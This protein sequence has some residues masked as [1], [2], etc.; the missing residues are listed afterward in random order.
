MNF[1][2]IKLSIFVREEKSRREKEGHILAVMFGCAFQLEDFF[3]LKN[4]IR[5][6]RSL[7]FALLLHFMCNSDL[8]VH[9]SVCVMALNRNEGQIIGLMSVHRLKLNFFLKEC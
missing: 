6:T 2:E 8:K 5:E 1:S 4:I 9:Y 3:H 7:L